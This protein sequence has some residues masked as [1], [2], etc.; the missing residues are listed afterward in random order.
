MWMAD[1]LIQLLRPRR[2]APIDQRYD[3]LAQ[4]TPQAGLV[5][6]KIAVYMLLR[7]AKY[8]SP[9]ARSTTRDL[10]AIEAFLERQPLLPFLKPTWEFDV[11]NLVMMMHDGRALE[12]DVRKRWDIVSELAKHLQYQASKH[13]QRAVLTMH[14]RILAVHDGDDMPEEMR[15]MFLM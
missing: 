2:R 12:L 5:S 1:T 8:N 7:F 6:A 11:Y 15:A 10:D 14:A 4:G 9:N 13:V 3:E